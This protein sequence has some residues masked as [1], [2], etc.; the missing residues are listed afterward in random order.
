MECSNMGPSHRLQLFTKHSSVGPF[1]GVQSFRNRLLWCGSPVGSQALPANLLQHGLLSP[2][3][4]RSCQEPAP[5]WCPQ[6]VTAS[7]GCIY[8]L[9]C[10]L[11]HRVQWIFAQLWTSVGCRGTACLTV[12]FTT[13]CRGISAAAPGA[14]PSPPSSLT[15]VSA[16]F[17]LT[18]SHCSLLLQLSRFLFLSLNMLSQRCYHSHWLA[19]PW[20]AAGL[21]WSQKPCHAKLIQSV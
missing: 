20:P 13:G 4:H 15:L 14:P 19:H 18:Y 11:F 7:S 5:T 6:R 17:F 12:V 16:E 21:S 8:L 3:V 1:H 10:G 9:R 2:Q